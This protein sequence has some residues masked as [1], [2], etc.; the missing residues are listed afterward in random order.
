M[1]SL[2]YNVNI[3]FAS[4]LYIGCQYQDGNL[5]ELLEYENQV[6]SLIHYL[7]TTVVYGK[8]LKVIFL[9]P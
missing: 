4:R 8:E 9:L 3:I 6:F 2:K 1:K 5:D 7:T